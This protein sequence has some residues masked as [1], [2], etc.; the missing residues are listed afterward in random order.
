[1][2]ISSPFS[3]A[4]CTIL[5]LCFVPNIGSAQERFDESQMARSADVYGYTTYHN[6]FRAPNN[7]PR[8]EY[9]A[10]GFM[11]TQDG[12]SIKSDINMMPMS[13]VGTPRQMM[14]PKDSN[15]ASQIEKFY[16]NKIDNN[17]LNQFGYNMF[18]H[19]ENNNIFNSNKSNI[20]APMGVVQDDYIIQVGDEVSI[21]FSGERKDRAT[22]KISSDGQLMIENF[23]AISVLGKTLAATEGEVRGYLSNFDYQGDV[24]LSVS[25]IRQIGVLVAG[26]VEKPGRHNLNAFH[27]LIDA[28]QMAGGVRRSGS[29]R[30]VK[31]IR[32]GKTDAIDLYGFLAD[33]RD[34][35]NIQLSDGDRIIVPPIG[36]TIAVSG[37]VKQPGIFELRANP[38]LSWRGQGGNTAVKISL[39]D[40]LNMA[41]GVLSTGQNQFLLLSSDSKL[42]NLNYNNQNVIQD[43][44]VLTVKR[45]SDQFNN[46]IELKGYSRKNGLY[47]VAGAPTLNALLNNWQVLG[48]DVYPL[49]GIVTR[50]DRQTLTRQMMGFSPQSIVQNKDDMQLEGG[51]TVYLFSYDNIAD[52]L[53]DESNEET[54]SVSKKDDADQFP[55]LVQDYV[56]DNIV[57]VNGAVGDSG[58][59]PI[60][61]TASIETVLS[62]AGGATNKADLS[63]IEFVS[64]DAQGD[65]LRRKINSEQVALN[66]INVMAGD[67]L[68]V[69]ERF[70]KAINQSV[71]LTGEVRHPGTYDLMRGDTLLSVLDRAGGVTVQAYPPGAVFSR[72]SERM[73]EE[74]RFR[75][76]AQDLERTVSV[77]LN[78]KDKDAALTP[79][80][81]SMARD[82]ADD[83]RSIQV[84]GRITVEADP[85]VLRARPELN[86]LLE[87]G[88]H[89]HI[90]KR[91]M[92]VRVSG[93]VLNPA[94]LMFIADKDDDDYVAEAG[95]VT[96]YA[97][98]SRKFVLY[99]DGSAKPLGG[100][101]DTPSMIIPGSTIVVPRDPKPF[102][103]M[104]SFKDITQILTN[105][106]ITGVFVEDIATDEN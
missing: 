72:K 18:H 3:R 20:I 48:N 26:H 27:S 47:D 101:N 86:P 93:E 55:R 45:S 34:L 1:M 60:G 6:Q 54:V 44:S 11:A 33:G 19:I 7:A 84:V 52:I 16:R 22:Y 67:Q 77:N 94:T 82:L 38:R 103:F 21:I 32:N 2:T 4:I 85:A 59:W 102:N 61:G 105:M 56:R 12:R 43:G 57:T 100:W 10:N 37:D 90:P 24:D 87:G 58:A 98:K 50:L 64:N 39:S 92:N 62:V 81:I 41:G 65:A 66:N 63:N 13:D 49:L 79:A 35:P 17:Q 9:D 89:I 5:A 75:A 69:G 106:A 83:L 23:P 53:N 71:K 73:R 74:Q 40:A 51:D 8:H 76:A 88:D 97:D 99:P 95:G 96:Y 29:L 30:N 31:L 80:Q 104:D 42:M 14:M 36:P 28:L 78:A 68:R 91:P 46:A 70:E 25:G 15:K